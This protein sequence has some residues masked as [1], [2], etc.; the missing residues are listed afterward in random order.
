MTHDLT[1]SVREREAKLARSSKRKR[2]T[3][4]AELS[5]VEVTSMKTAATLMNLFTLYTYEHLTLIQV[6]IYAY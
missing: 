3:S 4:A 6:A 1:K 5:E 2:K